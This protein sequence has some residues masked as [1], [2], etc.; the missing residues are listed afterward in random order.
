[1]FRMVQYDEFG[2]VEEWA[3]EESPPSEAESLPAAPHTPMR[4]QFPEAGSDYLGGVSDGW[5]YR[6]AFTG[7]KLSYVYEMVRQFLQEEGYGDVPLP[8][9]VAELKLFKK[10]RRAQLQLFSEKGYA[11]NPVKILFPTHPGQRNT[12]ILCIYNE[13]EPGHLLR[14]HGVA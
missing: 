4:E 13:K 3:E 12:L 2:F 14:F 6:T 11:H 5:E 9:T 10:P 8:E 7:S 1:M